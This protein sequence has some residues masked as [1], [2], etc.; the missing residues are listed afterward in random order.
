MNAIT[1]T[2]KSSLNGM[3]KIYASE[4]RLF[5]DDNLKPLIKAITDYW[6]GQNFVAGPLAA[7][8]QYIRVKSKSQAISDE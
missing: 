8:N 6:D 2:L 4:A 1:E 7:A 3:R 5:H